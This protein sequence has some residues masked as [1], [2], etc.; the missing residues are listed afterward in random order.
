MEARIYWKGSV[1]ARAAITEYYR[2]RCLK[3]SF[4]TVLEIEKSRVKI[5]AGSVS[6]E[7][8]LPG[9]HMTLFFLYLHM[10]KRE[11]LTLLFLLIR[12]LTFVRAPPS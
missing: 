6:G 5:L 4:L 1:L 2:P 11:V 12:A 3:H 8:L 7:G 9:V 10:G